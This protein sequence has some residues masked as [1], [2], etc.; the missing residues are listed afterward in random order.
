GSRLSQRVGGVSQINSDL[1][2]N[3]RQLTASFNGITTKAILFNASY[4]FTRARDESQGISTFGGGG[5]GFGGG[6]VASTAGNPNLSE[7]AT[8][9]Q[10][11]RHSLL[12]TITWPI[13]P[14]IELTAIARTTS[15]AFF[16]PLV[17]GHAHV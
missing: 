14:A 5:G 1:E 4:T 8:S 17:G 6:A 2:S 7:R 15:G 11:R 12:G 16:T 9:D 3:T 10:E 13:K